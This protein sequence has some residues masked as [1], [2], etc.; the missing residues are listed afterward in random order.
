MF[1]LLPA[2]IGWE[3]PKLVFTPSLELRSRLSSSLE[4][5]S[6]AQRARLGLQAQRLGVGGKVALQVVRGWVQAPGTVEVE[7]SYIPQL[8]EGWVS[9]QGQL[10]DNIELQA[11]VGRQALSVHEGRIL[12]ED[13][14][15]MEAQFFDA[16]RLQ[17]ELAPLHVEYLN[18]RRFG[19]PGGNPLGIGVNLLRVGAGADTPTLLWL[20]D[21]LWVVDGRQSSQL[22]STLGF[23]GKVEFRRL[24][25]RA[26]GY[27]QR[28]EEVPV[29]RLFAVQ[30]GW[31]FGENEGLVLST[32]MEVASGESALSSAWRPVLGD[33]HHFWGRVGAFSAATDYEAGGLTDL[34]IDLS[35][36]PLPSLRATLTGHHFGRN[37]GPAY[38]WELD[39]SLDWAFSPQVALG[40][41][42]GYLL[43]DPGEP[44]QALGWVQLDAAF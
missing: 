44:S 28:R 39:G 11:T 13:D 38:G 10:S 26:E 5:G 31:V 34:W 15:S 40:A 27:L 20:A 17:L 3:P 6:V 29:A 33:S 2:L 21:V 24:R 7:G 18:A 16:L 23:Y 37:Q 42:G 4:R 14:F 1:L 30:A 43:G 41:G 32:G 36:Q 9:W 25:A 8:A 35:T 22:S 19:E 12:G